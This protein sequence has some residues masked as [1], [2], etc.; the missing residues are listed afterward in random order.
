MPLRTYI[1]TTRRAG[2][3]A[4]SGVGRLATL[5]GGSAMTAGLFTDAGTLPAILTTIAAGLG[6]AFLSP[7]FQL[8]HPMKKPIVY[9]IYLT[10]HTV[11]VSNLITEL[12]WDATE[13]RLVQ[14]GVAVL[15]TAGVW[16]LRPGK[17]AKRVAKWPEPVIETEDT[18]GDGD[19]TGAEAEVAIAIPDDPAGRWWALNAA[20]KDGVAEGTRVIA[21]R[22]I[23][24]RRRVAVA[25]TA[26]EKGEPVPDIKIKRLS[27]LMNVPEELLEM[28][29]IPG[30][31]AGFA[32]LLI[33]PKP[34]AGP[35]PDDDVWAE[36]GRSA[37][38]G[39]TL[40]EINEY[41]MSKELHP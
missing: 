7:R 11:L 32:M 6:G 17:L 4:V 38:P 3:A 33:G 37:L 34:E 20:K 31:G 28:Q 24:D 25:L 27:A 36:I 5:A 12:A 16:W 10:P 15:W 1:Q 2:S 18:E 19:G 22:A 23:E 8:A 41:D 13:G 14:G 35:A 39:V 40:T 26:I 29:A 30:H 21:V 9:T